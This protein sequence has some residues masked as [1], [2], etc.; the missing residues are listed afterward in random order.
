MRDNAMDATPKS[1]RSLIQRMLLT[2]RLVIRAHDKDGG[3][4]P[5]DMVV[6]VL[7][8]CRPVM[9]ANR[10]TSARGSSGD[11]VKIVVVDGNQKITRRICGRPCAEVS[12][13]VK[14]GDCPAWK[15]DTSARRAPAAVIDIAGV[16]PQRTCFS[17]AYQALRSTSG[18][19]QTGFPQRRC[20]R[21]GTNW[22]PRRRL[23]HWRPRPQTSARDM[24]WHTQGDADTQKEERT[25][26]WLA[27]LLVRTG[28]HH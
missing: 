24:L 16:R 6:D 13:A 1:A 28:N 11:E 21:T 15:K 5:L 14:C 22:P 19:H 3:R 7:P 12:I 4:S 23:F 18:W 17:C 25:K 10:V 20:R 26:W 9:L 8:W 2:W 27:V